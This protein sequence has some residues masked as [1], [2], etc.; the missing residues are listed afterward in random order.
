MQAPTLLICIWS[1]LAWL[2]NYSAPKGG[3]STLKQHNDLANFPSV[4]TSLKSDLWAI[5][6]HVLHIYSSMS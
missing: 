6:K 5:F 2:A 3:T 4:K 1:S